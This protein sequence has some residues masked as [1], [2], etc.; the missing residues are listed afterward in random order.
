MYEA[1][2]ALRDLEKAI[3]DTSTG[4]AN[5][6][7]DSK[8]INQRLRHEP[9]FASLRSFL[10]RYERALEEIAIPAQRTDVT[11]DEFEVKDP[12]IGSDFLLCFKMRY[13]T[14]EEYD[15]KGPWAQLAAKVEIRNF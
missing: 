11:W 2:L 14:K 5:E 6:S 4:C 10:I 8:A 3:S 13:K 9:L 15:T 7:G 1:G 12:A